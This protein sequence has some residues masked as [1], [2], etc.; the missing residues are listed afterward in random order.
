M[1]DQHNGMSTNRFSRIAAILVVVVGV[2]S[3]IA[4]VFYLPSAISVTALLQSNA[5][6]SFILSGIALLAISPA[7]A[8]HNQRNL[9]YSAAIVVCLIASLTLLDYLTR[10]A[11][12]Q[13]Q[14]IFATLPGISEIPERGRMAFASSLCFLMLGFALLLMDSRGFLWLAELLAV[15]P[16]YVCFLALTS[17]AFRLASTSEPGDTSPGTLT[18]LTTFLL[19][20]G[21]L[22][23]RPNRVCVTILASQRMGGVMA[24]W[25]LPVGLLAPFG[26]GWLWLVCEQRDIFTGIERLSLFVLGNTIIFS[27]FIMRSAAAINRPDGQPTQDEGDFLRSESRFRTLVE[28]STD[29]I[30]MNGRKSAET[31]LR[32]N[33]ELFRG[34]FE[35][36]NVATVLTDIDNRFLRTNAAFAR[37]FGFSMEEM[38]GMSLVDVTHPDDLMESY[39]RRQELLAMRAT[40]FHMEKRYRHRDGHIFWGL[41]NVALVRN[42]EGLPLRYVGQIQDITER[43]RAEDALRVAEARFRTLI[44]QSIVGFYVFQD[45]RLVYV[46]P[47]MTEIFGFSSE[48][49]T[50]RPVLDFIIAEDRPQAQKNIRNRLD[51]RVASI[52]YQHRMTHSDGRILHVEVHGTRAEHNG[53]PA[54]L[55]ILLDITERHQ[56]EAALQESEARYRFL[57]EAMPQIVW[58]ARPNGELDYYN[59][60][61]YDYTSLSYEQTMADS[62]ELTL[63]PDDF[64]RAREMWEVACRT[65]NEFEVEYRLKRASDGEYRW[66]LGRAVPRRNSAGEIIQWVGTCTDID[67]QKR[68]QDALELLNAELEH[69]IQERTAELEAAN[70]EL[71]S[72][73]YSVSHDLRAP[74][75]AV[76]GFA[77][78]LVENFSHQMSDEAREHL[79]EVRDSARDMGRLVDD[80]LAFSRLGRQEVRMQLVHPERLVRQCLGEMRMEQEGRQ[81]EI[82]VAALAP[83]QGDA[84]L[85]KQVWANIL[86]NAL[87]YTRKREHARIEIGC[88]PD[89]EREGTVVYTVRDN[90]VGF[91]MRFAHKL[92]GVFQRLHRAEEYE[93]TG[94]GLAIVQRIVHRHGGRV[95]ANA[96]LGEGAAFFFT[97]VR[98]DP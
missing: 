80:L 3:I 60:R 63:H 6:L 92:F 21:I 28:N 9:G 91:D 75:R 55:G 19:G 43:K 44:E 32:E 31:A 59:R 24:R 8:N 51:G 16:V 65:S 12:G 62:W 94:V 82:I 27:L 30:T 74:L 20:I 15:V 36:T 54:I 93:G 97:L 11:L 68:A 73:S 85:L 13:D 10:W 46:N 70:K 5:G 90:G 58:T 87:K 50:S 33:E 77:R 95:W 45:D 84:G 29:A 66:H 83:C 88:Q 64:A 37:L 2:L 23:A 71:E 56:V 86:A 49:L 41:T 7:P 1:I 18:A 57:A 25:L 89:T 79:K 35:D 17:D 42:A 48:D 61:W 26:L 38:V 69:R 67:D 53:K 34:A 78:I 98:G 52:R 22:M 47:K 40:H 96:R 14:L 81:V 39:D 72:F 76:D 4:W